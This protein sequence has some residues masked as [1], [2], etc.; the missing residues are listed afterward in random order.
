[1]ADETIRP[2]GIYQP[3]QLRPVAGKQEHRRGGRSFREEMENLD[4]EMEMEALLKERQ[5]E[6]ESQSGG[7]DKKDDS[8]PKG[9]E[10]KGVGKN[11]D[12][13]T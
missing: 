2:T 6:S 11:L 5:D 3:N 10:S 4:D 13:S 1:M 9:E 7:Q 12:V 8:T